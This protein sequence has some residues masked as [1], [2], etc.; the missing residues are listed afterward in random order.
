MKSLNSYA[1]TAI[2]AGVST[3]ALSAPAES[4][5]II[6]NTNIPIPNPGLGVD[7]NADG[8]I[9]FQLNIGGTEGHSDVLSELSM[10]PSPV[11]AVIEGQ[12]TAGYASALMRGAAIGPNSPFGSSIGNSKFRG[13]QEPGISERSSPC[14]ASGAHPQGV[15]IRLN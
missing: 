10:Q 11:N 12:V 7:L 2:L 15:P 13:T 5:V 6:K 3:L 1:L 9:D 8:I 4:E 14:E